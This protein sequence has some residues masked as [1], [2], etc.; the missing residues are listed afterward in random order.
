MKVRIAPSVIS[1]AIPRPATISTS[2]ANDRLN[3]EDGDEETVPQSRRQARADGE[4]QRE[5][6]RITAHAG[7]GRDRAAESP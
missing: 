1:W 7:G 5:D 4:R 2:V 6:E 3:V